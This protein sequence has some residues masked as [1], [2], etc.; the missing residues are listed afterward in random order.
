MFTKEK[1]ELILETGKLDTVY[2]LTNGRGNFKRKNEEGVL[3]G[4]EKLQNFVVRG[5]SVQA[6]KI[7][8]EQR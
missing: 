3:R 2:R 5:I 4:Y 8:G 1:L 6:K 7:K